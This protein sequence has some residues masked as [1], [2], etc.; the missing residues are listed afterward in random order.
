MYWSV[1]HGLGWV[2][3]GNLDPCTSLLGRVR[4]NVCNCSK[5]VKSHVFWTL[6]KTLKKRKNRTYSFTGH[7]VTQPL[8]TQLPE[9]STGKSRSPTSNISCSEVWTQETMQLRTVCDK[10]LYVSTTS[11]SF[12][13]KISIDIQQ[14]WYFLWLF[15]DFL[16]CH[17]KKEVKVMFFWN[18]KKNK[19]RVL[20]HC[21]CAY[22]DDQ[23]ICT[24][25]MPGVSP[26]ETYSTIRQQYW[27]LTL[28]AIVHLL[29]EKNLTQINL[30]NKH[31]RSCLSL[32]S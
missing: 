15:N 4:E 26:L 22:S 20:E 24:L 8:I 10:R 17:F 7:L 3:S 2:R 18:L 9:V 27:L 12:E 6:K 31:K 16:I 29:R 5:N 21:C 25:H 30:R 32:L 23:E 19:I 11:G 14:T 1:I 13:A 28:S